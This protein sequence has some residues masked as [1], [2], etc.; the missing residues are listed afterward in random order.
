MSELFYCGTSNVE[1]P[2]PNKSYFPEEYKDKSR[3]AY[4]ASLFNTVEIN[5][6]FYKIP[7]RRAVERWAT[8][9]PGDFR[10][11]FKLW[12]GITHA[13]ELMYEPADVHK[14]MQAINGAGARKG[15]LLL[16]LPASVKRSATK[17]LRLLLDELS[18]ADDISGWRLAIEFRDKSWYD[19]SVYQMLEQ[20]QAA[21]VIHDMP[22]SATPLIDMEAAF[23]YMRFHG[24]VGDYRGS[25]DED[26]LHDHAL[27]IKEHIDNERP[28]FVYFNNTIGGAVADA[29]RLRGLVEGNSRARRM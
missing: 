13:K 24:E 10:F 8:D 20:Y 27:I 15:C 25:Y 7:M 11:T 4:Y 26:L 19:D 9:V 21:V 3:L 29:M 28:V 23:V 22:A 6:S 14:F 16:Q 5:S 17:K 1:L 18:H 12:R 2:V